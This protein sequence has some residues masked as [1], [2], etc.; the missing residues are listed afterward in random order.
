MMAASSA[1]TT[2]SLH[3]ISRRD[4]EMTLR[5]RSRTSSRPFGA[6]H[7]DPVTAGAVE[8]AAGVWGATEAADAREEKWRWSEDLCPH[9]PD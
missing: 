6:G 8:L 3:E 4:Q 9:L 2:K 5:G 1:L 7:A